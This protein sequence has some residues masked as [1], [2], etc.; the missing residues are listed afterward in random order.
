MSE[1]TASNSKRSMKKVSFCQTLHLEK[2]Y[3]VNND[4]YDKNDSLYFKCRNEPTRSIKEVEEASAMLRTKST[5]Y[6][7]ALG[8]REIEVP[9]DK[10]R[11]VFEQDSTL[12]LRSIPD[13]EQEIELYAYKNTRSETKQDISKQRWV[14]TELFPHL[15]FSLKQVDNFKQMLEKDVQRRLETG[16]EITFPFYETDYFIKQ[17]FIFHRSM[18][19]QTGVLEEWWSNED[20]FPD[21]KF[22]TDQVE[23]VQKKIHKKLFKEKEKE[24]NELNQH[25]Q[26]QLK[27]ESVNGS[28]PMRSAPSVS[29]ESS[30]PT[31]GD[32]RKRPPP[33]HFQ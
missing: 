10:E 16:V 29:E 3:H 9:C 15:R 24:Q 6:F 20:K 18:N 32:K 21:T 25:I 8:F 1:C 7:K 30:A 17:G 4:G 12:S 2:R 26:R 23:K 27:R 19:E 28:E 33:R 5:S 11:P 31:V 14:H 22:R 13:F